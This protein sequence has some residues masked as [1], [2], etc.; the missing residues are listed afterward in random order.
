MTALDF[1]ILVRDM[2]QLQKDY[3]R[4]RDREV[5]VKSKE[6]EKRVDEE[7]RRV[8]DFMNKHYGT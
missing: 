4:T 2:R 3:F 6:L 1:F 8:S 5:L 7:I